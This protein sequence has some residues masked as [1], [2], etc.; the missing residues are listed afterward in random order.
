MLATTLLERIVKF[1]H[2]LTLVLTQ[3]YRGFYGDV[4]VQ[5]ARVAGTHAFD[6][7]PTQA[8]LLTALCTFRDINRSFSSQRRNFNF[9][10]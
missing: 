6:A 3:F 1:A 9:S 4:A 7:F 10:S 8:E 2:Q 5:V